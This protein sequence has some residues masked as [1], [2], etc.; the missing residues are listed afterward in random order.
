LRKWQA[1]K[2]IR[3]N[4][5]KLDFQA[6]PWMRMT[7][8]RELARQLG[9]SETAVRRAE[10]AGRISREADGAWDLARVMLPGVVN[11]GP[12]DY[13]ELIARQTSGFTKNVCRRRAHLV[14]IEVVE[15]APKSRLHWPATT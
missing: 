12:G 5:L 1:E 15:A 6:V 13:Y 3:I 14:R 9:V 11:V 4:D 8:N 10:K 7:S 2:T